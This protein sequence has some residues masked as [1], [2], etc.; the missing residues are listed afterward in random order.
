MA[1]PAPSKTEDELRAA[2]RAELEAEHAARVERFEAKRTVARERAREHHAQRERRDVEE[3]RLAER[4][5]FYQEKGYREYVDSN[6]RSEW[7][8][9]AEY[10]WRTQRRKRRD[11]RGREYHPNLVKRRREL[12]LYAV[13]VVMAL[14]IGLL[15]V[16]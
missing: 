7:L 10:E 4:R 2:I 15:L 6:G 5:R 8:T 9:P 13:A 16:R 3:L 12:V 11:R 1:E 14:V